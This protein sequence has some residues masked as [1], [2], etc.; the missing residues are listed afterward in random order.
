MTIIPDDQQAARADQLA[1][2]IEKY[3]AFLRANPDIAQE[4]SDDRFLIY[5]MPGPDAKQ[6]MADIIR[7]GMRSGATVTKRANDTYAGA[8][9]KF[10]RVTLEVYSDREVVCERRVTGTREVEV[11]EQDPEALAQVP[12]RTVT[13]VVEDVEWVC[14]PILDAAKEQ[15]GAAS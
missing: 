5:L 7:R 10:G 11:E 4:V 6:Q 15:A 13:K 3:A 1:T 14:T 8:Q 2:D 9:M 12:V